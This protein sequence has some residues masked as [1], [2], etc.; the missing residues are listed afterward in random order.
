MTG[1]QLLPFAIL[2]ANNESNISRT[3]NPGDKL[4]IDLVEYVTIP[5]LFTLNAPTNDEFA[6]T[7]P[8]VY[9]VVMNLNVGWQP[10]VTG[11]DMIAVGIVQSDSAETVVGLNAWQPTETLGAP[12]SSVHATGIG[13]IHAS[14]TNTFSI[15][16]LGTGGIQVVDLSPTNTISNT[17]NTQVA[18][19]ISLLYVGPYTP[20][21][22]DGT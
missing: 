2:H 6:V 17:Y 14:G 19:D 3:Y 1:P 8:G 11:P 12:P 18:M 13:R 4:V 21:N 9:Q 5:N 15:Q 20:F 7:V 16:N 10:G 22:P